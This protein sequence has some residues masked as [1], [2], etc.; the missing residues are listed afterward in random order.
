MTKRMKSGGKNLPV[1]E[2][3]RLRDKL[4]IDADKANPRL[5]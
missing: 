2:V 5:S 3:K 4:G 1:E